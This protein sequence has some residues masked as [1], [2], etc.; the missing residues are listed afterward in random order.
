MKDIFNN[1]I[2]KKDFKDPKDIDLLIELCKK[3]PNFRL[4]Y[5]LLLH[6]QPDFFNQ[7]F[8]KKG[9]DFLLESKSYLKH[10]YEGAT[11][12][13]FGSLNRTLGADNSK[14]TD[15]VSILRKFLE[16]DIPKFI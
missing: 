4:P 6:Y 2:Q 8:W 13:E 14:K 7:E 10:Y 12:Q 5:M 16:K 1:I 9:E 11:A 3:Y 15:Q